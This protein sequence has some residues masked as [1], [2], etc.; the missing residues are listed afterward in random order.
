MLFLS[1][2]SFILMW[3]DISIFIFIKFII[4]GGQYKSLDANIEPD[5]DNYLNNGYYETTGF[6]ASLFQHAPSGINDS[7]E[8]ILRV[9]R[10]YEQSSLV[11]QVLFVN[12]EC[13]Y[14]VRSKRN[15][16][17]DWKEMTMDMPSF[18]KNYSDLA[19]LA[20]A[21]GGLMYIGYRDDANIIGTYIITTPGDLNNQHFPADGYYWT[22]ISIGNTSIALCFQI[23]F[24]PYDDVYFRYYWNG[25]KS[26]RAL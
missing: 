15:F 8:A 6:S 3:F 5:L 21:I 16:W 18:Y 11:E 13:R 26:W 24:N 14:Y 22:L 2:T 25:W 12:N 10:I 4:L 20:S 7:N 1:S 23:A 17:G 19:S 9:R